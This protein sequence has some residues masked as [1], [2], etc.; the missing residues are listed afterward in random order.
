MIKVTMFSL[1]ACVS[2]A[3]IVG[4][5]KKEEEEAKNIPLEESVQPSQVS[6]EQRKRDSIL[7][8]FN[9]QL[10]TLDEKIQDANTRIS[11]MGKKKNGSWRNKVVVVE[12][13]KKKIVDE[14]IELEKK[15]N[16]QHTS[17]LSRLNTS[18]ELLSRDMDQI[19]KKMK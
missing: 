8:G 11:K 9:A 2:A 19:L 17:E 18:V 1:L 5:C 4:G 10:K 15:P 7:E 12:A 16:D 13:K 3:L 6:E 14:A